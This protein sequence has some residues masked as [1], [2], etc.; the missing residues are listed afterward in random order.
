MQKTNKSYKSFRASLP[1]FSKRDEIVSSIR[2][3]QVTLIC[4]DTGCG[5]TTQVPQYIYEENLHNNKTIGVTQ[6]RRIAAMTVSKRVAEEF[7]CNYGETVGYE[8]RFESMTTKETKIKFMTEGILLR[9][10]TLDLHLKQYSI[11]VIDEA[12]ERGIN[13]DVLLGLVK[14]QLKTRSDLRI[15]VMSA[16]LET[17][18][19][20]KFFNKCN[21][22][23]V[24]GRF[25]PIEIYNTEEPQRD[26]LDAALNTILQ[27]H[28]EEPI[29]ASEESGQTL[30]GD[31]QVFL[32]GQEEIEDLEDM[33]KEKILEFTENMPR[34]VVR[35]L[36]AA[37]PPHIQLEAFAPVTNPNER[38]VILATNIAETSI[39]ID[40]VKYVID[41][42]FVKIR[43]FEANKVIESLQ[44]VPISKSSAVQRAGRAGRQAKGKCFRIF[45]KDAFNHLEQ[46]MMPE[47]LR[48]DVS[49]V[50][51]HLKSVGVHNILEFPFIDRPEEMFLRVGEETLKKMGAITIED[52]TLTE[53]G[54]E[55]LEQPLEPLYS[56]AIIKSS[57]EPDY[58]QKDFLSIIALMNV[59]NLL[60]TKKIDKNKMGKAYARFQVKNSDHLTK[61]Q[62]LSGYVSAR[63]R[64]EFCKEYC[65]NKRAI[66]KVIA[67]RE[68]LR[69]IL[70]QIKEKR[71]HKATDKTGSKYNYTYKKINMQKTNMNELQKNVDG[72]HDLDRDNLLK[73][74]GQ[75]FSTKIAHLNI[76]GSYSVGFLAEKSKAF[77]HPES[78]VFYMKQKPKTIIYNVVVTT[79]KT[80]LRDVSEVKLSDK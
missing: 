46:F 43:Y 75:G 26:Y 33:L 9:E 5:K 44:N 47:I 74:L 24:K 65:V 36:Y 76:D 80:Y 58:I 28:L 78:V 61:L 77:I 8:I 41:C 48:S 20:L 63:N 21:I 23:N 79:K 55:I 6:P 71:K 17:E 27:I 15:V 53:L 72:S 59:E 4:G 31:I 19:I 73:V 51:L 11:L 25:Y 66:E 18:R 50:I 16:T 64:N 37:L 1:I 68:Q 52:G 67:I 38:K 13:C 56:A 32:T 49:Q 69:L 54:R 7:G 45:P 60:F 34:L 14:R 62:M 22:I 3:N 39:T 40:G 70:E 42:G 30:N 10:M 35:S 57:D 29:M 12:H 2:N